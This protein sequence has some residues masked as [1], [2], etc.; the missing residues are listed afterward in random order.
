MPTPGRLP[1]SHHVGNIHPVPGLL[2]AMDRLIH[3]TRIT[4]GNTD[5]AV[6]QEVVDDQHAVATLQV[7]R[8]DR[9]MV[10]LIFPQ[11]AP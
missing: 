10:I 5:V 11:R 7:T 9:N 4:E 8:G 6:G 2:R 3:I 1:W